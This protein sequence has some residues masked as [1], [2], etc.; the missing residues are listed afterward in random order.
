MD[1]TVETGQTLFIC[2]KIN[3]DSEIAM[4]LKDR[5]PGRKW[6]INSDSIR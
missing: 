1:K 5:L 4:K 3:A 6:Q 2:F